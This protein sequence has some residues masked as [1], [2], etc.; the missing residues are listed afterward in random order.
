MLGAGGHGI[1]IRTVVNSSF[2][3][4]WGED[5]DGWGFL[6]KVGMK[7]TLKDSSTPRYT[8]VVGWWWRGEGMKRC[9]GRTIFLFSLHWVDGSWGIE[10]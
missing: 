9:Q 3:C 6:G 5:G 10:I 1:I 4:G 2:H 7:G 8:T